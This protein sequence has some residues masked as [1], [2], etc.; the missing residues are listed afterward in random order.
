MPRRV[1][2]KKRSKKSG[3]DEDIAL[4]TDEDEVITPGP[5]TPGERR[6]SGLFLLRDSFP[7]FF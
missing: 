2:S 5:S 1:M 6:T 7:P 4:D 3:S